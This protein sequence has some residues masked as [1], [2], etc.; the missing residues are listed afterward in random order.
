MENACNVIVSS[1]KI[2]H[3]RKLTNYSKCLLIFKNQLEELSLWCPSEIQGITA[4]GKHSV[5]KYTYWRTQYS[6]MAIATCY[7]MR[8]IK[9]YTHKAHSIIPFTV[10]F[11][12]RLFAPT[13]QRAQQEEIFLV[14]MGQCHSS[15]LE[16]VLNLI[17]LE[18]CH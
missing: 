4:H 17:L 13:L 12:L 18:I 2:W 11:V 5:A 1:M 9:A 8:D 15:V 6:R 14:P 16:T 7:I 10:V 3:F